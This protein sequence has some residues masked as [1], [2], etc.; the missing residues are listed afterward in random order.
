MLPLPL[1]REAV[2]R[3]VS[4]MCAT[5]E[6][7]AEGRERGLP[8]E[9]CTVLGECVGPFGGGTF[10]QYQ[11][12]ISDPSRWCLRCGQ[13]SVAAV[14]VAGTSPLYGM[15]RVHLR[16]AHMVT[17]LGAQATHLLEIVRL[18]HKI[19]VVSYIPKPRPFTRQSVTE[20]LA[21]IDQELL[22]RGPR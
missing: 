9:Q 1:V 12:P 18:D 5:C 19:Q 22:D 14:R 10:P 7:Y 11:G 20:L 13:T 15:C 17:P 4:L 21:E 3:G 2:D 6:R 8:E 16:E